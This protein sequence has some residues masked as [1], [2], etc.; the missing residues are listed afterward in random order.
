MSDDPADVDDADEPEVVAA[1]EDEVEAWAEWRRDQTERL[2]VLG[3]VAR[4][5]LAAQGFPVADHPT[6]STLIGT[7]IQNLNGRVRGAARRAAID[8]LR[9]IQR[10]ANDPT[11]PPPEPKE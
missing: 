9:A 8:V 3:E 1:I 7:M 4:V 5:L 11:G 6:D 10:I 2:R